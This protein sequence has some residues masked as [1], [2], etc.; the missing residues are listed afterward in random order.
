MPTLKTLVLLAATAGVTPSAFILPAASQQVTTQRSEEPS[1]GLPTPLAAQDVDSA[2][3]AAAAAL[4]R[5]GP[6][7]AA[8]DYRSLGFTSPAELTT[9]SVGVPLQIAFVPLDKLA[10]FSSAQ[11]AGTLITSGGG[12]IVP[13]LVGA[14]V[15]CAVF[16]KSS[17]S[18]Y[19][20]IGIGQPH[21]AQLI[22]QTMDAVAAEKNASPRSSVVYPVHPRSRKS[23][24]EIIRKL[25]VTESQNSA[26]L[27]GTSSRRYSRVV[28]ANSPQVP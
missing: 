16:L 12:L 7:A 22:S 26:H 9:A 25:S 15:R 18:G 27:L 6:S 4:V 20:G 13:V 17:A 21:M 19:V 11:D 24:G 5:F 1:P 14:E 10:A 28:S 2:R 8:G 23:L 3:A